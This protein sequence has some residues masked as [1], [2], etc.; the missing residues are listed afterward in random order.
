M[1]PNAKTDLATYVNNLNLLFKIRDRNLSR[2]DSKMGSHLAPNPHQYLF[3]RYLSAVSFWIP[4]SFFV[5][6]FPAV[7]GSHFDSRKI[8]FLMGASSQNDSPKGHPKWDQKRG[9][10][11]TPKSIN[12]PRLGVPKPDTDAGLVSAGGPFCCRVV[13][14]RA[15]AFFKCYR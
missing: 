13:V 6:I 11:M 5:S 1:T 7:F 10:K 9:P 8:Q 14:F 4:M 12:R 3:L 2:H 15:K